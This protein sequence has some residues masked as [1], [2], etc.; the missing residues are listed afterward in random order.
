MPEHS[1][2]GDSMAA[3]LAFGGQLADGLT[4]GMVGAAS[5]I[6]STGFA[7]SLATGPP[8][9]FIS[10]PATAATAAIVEFLN[11]AQPPALL[12]YPTCTTTRSR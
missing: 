10:A 5:Q 1:P 8:I 6:H 9:R 3:F 2:L 7:A 11:D 12:G 4:V